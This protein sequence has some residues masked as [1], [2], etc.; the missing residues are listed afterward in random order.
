MRRRPDGPSVVVR[1]IITVLMQTL[2][3][4]AFAGWLVLLV[5]GDFFLFLPTP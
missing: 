2:V 3:T 5:G 4:L 1:V